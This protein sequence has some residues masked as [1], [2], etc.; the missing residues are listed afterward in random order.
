MEVISIVGKDL[1]LNGILYMAD[2]LFWLLLLQ[3]V[4]E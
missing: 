3:R 1:E 2:V 4:P